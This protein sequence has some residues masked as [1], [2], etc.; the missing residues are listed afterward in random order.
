MPDFGEDWDAVKQVC[1][2]FALGRVPPEVQ[3]AFLS[4]RVLAGAKKDEKV[5]PFALGGI[6]R[7]CIS[8][9]VGRVFQARVAAA[10]GPTQYAIGGEGGAE[11]MH[12]TVL[13]DLDTRPQAVLQSFD[14]ANAHNEFDREEALN[15]VD[16]AVPEML[17]WVMAGFSTDTMHV[18]VGPSG[19]K[20][21]LP[22]SS[23][24]DQGDA[25]VALVFP[26]V[27]SKVIRRTEEAAKTIDPAARAY[28]YQDDLDIVC[29]PG[30]CGETRRVFREACHSIG[31][32]ANE[33]KETIAL[34]REVPIAAR[35]LG[36][37]IIARPLVL[38]HGATPLPALPPSVA[39]PSP[40][41]EENS[42][43]V[44]KIHQNREALYKRL[45]ALK[46]AGL[47]S[48]EVLGLLKLRTGA[49]YTFVARC[50]GLPAGDAQ[51]LDKDL[52]GTVK[53]IIGSDDWTDDAEKRCFMLVASSDKGGGLGFQSTVLTAA[54][55]HAASWQS[56]IGKITS[57][58]GLA[59][60]SAL[61]AVSPWA[62]QCVP[63]VEATIREAA[64]DP[65]VH[66]GDEGFT[67]S[68]QILAAARVKTAAD[69]IFDSVAPSTAAVIFSAGGAGAAGCLS[70]LLY[71][72]ITS[73]TPNSRLQCARVYTSTSLAARGGADTGKAMV[74]CAVSRWTARVRTQDHVLSVDGWSEGTTPHARFWRIGAGSRVA[75]STWKSSS[76]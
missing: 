36:A 53:A 38:R 3:V 56:S 65:G 50:C 11:V 14:V 34:G 21:W 70:C 39:R 33:D 49:D 57:R 9:A 6:L 24:G 42:P 71:Q 73:S 10:V 1:L 31:V 40:V 62:A 20:Q 5:R 47:S 67:G 27:Y 46:R 8:K 30:A 41:L 51:K 44:Q 68:Q 22:K 29:L 75:K 43:E 37:K 15:E 52:V 2:R 63:A 12:K 25:E 13:C 16:S 72:A 23:G 66:L 69:D 60:P 28:G 59:A 32:R 18:Y 26:L 64:N 7:R 19:E 48:Q 45:L 35:P 4:S 61:S 76:L 55:A 54:A 58:L 74:R 17:P